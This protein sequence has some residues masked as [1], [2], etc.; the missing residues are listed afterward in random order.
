MASFFCLLIHTYSLND[1]LSNHIQGKEVWNSQNDR[2]WEKQKFEGYV[3]GKAGVESLGSTEL[4]ILIFLL[5]A[6][7]SW[8]TF[9]HFI[10][11]IF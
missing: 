5:N 10:I 7:L 9:L 11:I 1:D 3:L 6:L 8:K 2:H 4:K